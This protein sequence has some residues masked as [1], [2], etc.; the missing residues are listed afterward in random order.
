MTAPDL[1]AMN[2][3]MSTRILA[4]PP[5]PLVEGGYALRVV[6]TTGRSSGSPRTTPL[7]VVQ[8]DGALYLVSP[9]PGR[10]WVRNLSA[11]P[12]CVLD[13]GDDARTAV[14]APPE[15]AAPVV[16][17]Y[18]RAMTQPWALRAFPVGPEASLEEITAHLDGMA[19]LR[20]DPR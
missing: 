7:G 9:D 12:A 19:V 17:A 2:A 3:A 8:H 5:Q 20:L 14:P 6:R 18:L 13:P 1:V 16:S 4:E 10:D 11:D 15:Q